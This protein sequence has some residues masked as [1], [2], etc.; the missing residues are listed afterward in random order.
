MSLDVAQVGCFVG[1][2]WAA[3]THAVC[4]L[5][6]AGRKMALFRV[7]HTAEGLAGML[8]RLRK[9]GDPEQMPVAIE[10]PDGRLVD[11]LLEAGHPVVPVKPNAIKSWREGEVV[12]GA[13]SDDADALV[14]ASEKWSRAPSPTTPTRW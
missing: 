13:K 10:R 3:S 11:A 9:L 8:R 5:D 2:D 14:I 12:S 7:E 4:V 1:I 6:A